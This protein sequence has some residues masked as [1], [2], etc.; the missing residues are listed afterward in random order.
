MAKVGRN[1]RCH[2]GSGKKYKQCCGRA[3]GELST[4]ARIGLLAAAVAIV[5]A[6]L[7]GIGSRDDEATGPNRVWSAEH[8]HYHDVQ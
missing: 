5:A 6:F 4:R 8:G 7:Y 2:C 1:E 3:G